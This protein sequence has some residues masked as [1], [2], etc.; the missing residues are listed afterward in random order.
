MKRVVLIVSGS[1]GMLLAGSTMAQAVRLGEVAGNNPRYLQV[2]DSASLRPSNLTL[3]C[4]T[5]PMGQGYGNTAS[6]ALLIGRPGQGT[7]GSYLVSWGL[8]YVVSTGKFF[9]EMAGP[10]FATNGQAIL[11]NGAVPL[12]GTAHVAATYDGQ[13][14]K[15]YINGVLDN[16]VNATYPAF[17]YTRPDNV[18][19]GA[20]NYLF[21]FERRFDG[22]L[23]EVRIWNVARTAA[24]ISGGQGRP[25]LP[26][27]SGAGGELELHRRLAP[28]YQREWEP[29]DRGHGGHVPAGTLRADGL[30]R[31]LR[32][33]R[34]RACP[35]CP[36]LHLLHQ[37]VQQRRSAGQL[38]RVHDSTSAEHSGLHLLP[39]QVCDWVSV[40]ARNP[41]KPHSSRLQGGFGPVARNVAYHNSFKK[42]SWRGRPARPLRC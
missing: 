5:H 9:F 32:L 36:G 25:H 2:V 6:G 42:P 16:Q 1:A 40:A 8:Y 3:E 19:F 34:D 14:I 24:Q 31:Q 13:T 23:D 35:Q 20:A 27:H 21:G 10:V 15:L 4:W 11:S 7:S 33:L 41:A 12:G 22:T 28:R 39:E 26:R 29:R 18:T 38:R 17:N 30:L 37:P